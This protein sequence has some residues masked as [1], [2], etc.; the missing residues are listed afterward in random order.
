MAKAKFDTLDHTMHFRRSFLEILSPS[1]IDD[2]LR[3]QKYMKNQIGFKNLFHIDK[4]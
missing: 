3:L 1:N 2:Y 4:Q